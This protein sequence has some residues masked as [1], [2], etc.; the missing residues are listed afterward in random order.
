[1]IP[2][3]VPILFISTI[4][5]LFNIPLN[6]VTAVIAAVTIGISVDDT[7]HFM[8]QYRSEK[9]TGVPTSLALQR[10]I[11]EKGGAIISTSV[12][13]SCGFLILVTASFIPTIQFGILCSLIMIIAVIADLLILPSIIQLGHK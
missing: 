2:N 8:Y 5:V 1:L 4:M 7:I 6:A 12:I 3:I 9:N 13:V 10:T 11:K